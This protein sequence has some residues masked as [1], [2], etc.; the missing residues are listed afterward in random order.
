[1]RLAFVLAAAAAVT[2]HT[3]AA[4]PAEAGWRGYPAGY[5]ACYPHFGYY[6]TVQYWPVVRRP[7]VHR[8]FRLET[9]R[10]INIRRGY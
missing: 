10:A 4:G 9:Y 2:A 7:P 8:Y 1:M 3:L 6:K 5:G